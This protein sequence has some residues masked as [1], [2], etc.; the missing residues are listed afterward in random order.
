MVPEVPGAVM[1][2]GCHDYEFLTH[3]HDVVTV[4]V[5]TQGAVEIEVDNESF[6]A[7]RGQLVMIGAHQIHSARPANSLGWKM[8]TAH[9]PQESLA[10]FLGRYRIPL[11]ETIHF[12][13]SLHPKDDGGSSLFYEMHASLGKAGSSTGR[14][15]KY[16]SFMQ[17]LGDNIDAF[18]PQSIPHRISDVQ[19]EQARKI[20]SKRVFENVPIDHIAEEAGLS[21]YSFIRRF[22]K[23]Y[24][25][26]PHA[27]RM[28]A[29]ANEAAQLLREKVRLVDVA[30]S[31]GFSDQPHMARI[32]KKT[33]GVTPGQYRLMH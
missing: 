23:N 22:E 20:I 17:W 30:A 12:S 10:A 26:S 18:G 4:I 16:N 24:G 32:F 9:L 5:V 11:R 13:R 3:S 1:F 21:V 7:T 31:C 25:I 29:R 8:R 6:R 27:W 2:H 33:F 28:Q 15:D 14:L 19:L